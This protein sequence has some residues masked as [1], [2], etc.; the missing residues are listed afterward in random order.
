M[1]ASSRVYCRQARPLRGITGA[2]KASAVVVSCSSLPP[3]KN[4]QY[5]ESALKPVPRPYV[6]GVYG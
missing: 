1:A 2:G 3:G 5:G 4:A 6:A